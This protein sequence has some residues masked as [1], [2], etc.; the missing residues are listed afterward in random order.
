MPTLEEKIDLVAKDVGDIKIALRGYNGQNGLVKRV[1]N[2]TKQ[3]NKLWITIAIIAASAGGGGAAI[4]K[5][6]LGS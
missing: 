4:I 6:I 5:A 3:I 2:N 1:E